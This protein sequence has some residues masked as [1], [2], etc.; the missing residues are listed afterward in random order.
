MSRGA[1]E[2]VDPVKPGTLMGTSEVATELS[3]PRSTVARWIR[4]G[5]LPRPVD[6][7]KATPVWRTSDIRRFKA[8]LAKQTAAR[9]QAREDAAA[10]AAAA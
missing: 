5:V 10:A 1:V 6:Q 8:K 3:V 7:L 4:S 2:G 9:D